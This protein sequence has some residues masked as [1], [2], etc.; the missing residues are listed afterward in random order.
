MIWKTIDS[1]PRDRNILLRYYKGGKSSTSRQ[2]GIWV[3]IEGKYT[4]HWNGDAWFDALDR[5]IVEVNTLNPKNKVTH[6]MELP[7]KPE[8][9]TK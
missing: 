9:E 6:W 8:E 1:A 2:S 7:P 4:A 5:L 3:V